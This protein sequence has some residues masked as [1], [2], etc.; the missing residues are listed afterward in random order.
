MLSSC[1]SPIVSS[2]HNVYVGMFC[3]TSETLGLGASYQ[4]ITGTGI[5]IGPRKFAIGWMRIECLSIPDRV[6]RQSISSPI[7]NVEIS[8]DAATALRLVLPPN[9][10]E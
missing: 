2:G 9:V 8:P 7:A 1:A 3:R 5:S 10:D 6:T 4:H